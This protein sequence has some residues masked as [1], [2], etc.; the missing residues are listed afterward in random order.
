[1]AA[2]PRIS[3]FTQA[4]NTSRELIVPRIRPAVAVVLM[5]VI[6]GAVSL[7]MYALLDSEVAVAILGVIAMTLP[8]VVAGYLTIAHPLLVAFAGVLLIWCVQVLV[9]W[10]V[11]DTFSVEL[12]LAFIQG[13]IVQGVVLCV[14][15]VAAHAVRSRFS[16][17]LLEG[18]VS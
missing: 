6:H 14:S 5:V 16:K 4:L 2:A 3:Q 17:R 18:G 1:M 15:C 8:G 10:F 7:I 9:T 12:L 11:V 13:G